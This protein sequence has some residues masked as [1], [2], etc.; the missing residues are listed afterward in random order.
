MRDF[1]LLPLSELKRK[2]TPFFAR[3]QTQRRTRPAFAGADCRY[4]APRSQAPTAS[5]P[6]C[7]SAYSPRLSTRGF[8]P[9]VRQALPAYR[10]TLRLAPWH[11]P[12]LHIMYQAPTRQ[13]PA[14]PAIRTP[15]AHG[16]PRLCTPGAHD[17]PLMCTSVA[18]DSSRI[19][20]PG[21]HG[22]SCVAQCAPSAPTFLAGLRFSIRCR[23]SACQIRKA[24]RRSSGRASTR[25]LFFTLA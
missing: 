14:I 6:P 2:R 1:R 15:S 16:P 11:R 23:A 13:P 17:F 4:R 18:H 25:A 10:T 7:P 12:L 24:S 20:T 8:H 22:F 19:C 21:V 3:R 9:T 5:G